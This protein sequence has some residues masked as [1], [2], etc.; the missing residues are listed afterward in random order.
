MTKILHMLANRHLFLG[1]VLWAIAF[2]WPAGPAKASHILGGE[3][4]YR[5]LGNGLFEFTIKV[6]RDCN[7]IPW[8]QTAMALQGPQGTTNLPIIPG[9]PDDI[10]PRCPGSTYLSCNPPTSATGQNQGSVA[11]Y[12]FRGIV[13]LSALG[14]AP[15]AGYTFNTTQAGNGIPCC[16]PTIDNS[17]AD[18]GSQT[19][20]VKMFP[21]RD[22][23]TNLLLSPAQLCDNS[24]EFA[25]DP[26]SFAVLNPVD[27]IFM[28]SLAFDPDLDSTRFGIDFPLGTSVTAPYAYTAPYTVNNPIPGLMQPPL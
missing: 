16:R 7:G 19:L 17:T 9:S 4:T 10:S 22:P 2:V 25:T 13:D 3:I 24:P 11:R 23:N 6:Y 1:L 15:P 5:C 18:N 12:V 26:T 28:Q 20:M 14:P 21:Y 27:T 8:T